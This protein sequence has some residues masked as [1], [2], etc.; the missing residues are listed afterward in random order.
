MVAPP[1]FIGTGGVGSTSE[2]I[3]ETAESIIRRCVVLELEKQNAKL[4]MDQ[5]K[6]KINS[7]KVKSS[8][9]RQS[10]FANR[11]SRENGKKRKKLMRDNFGEDEKE[12]LK[13]DDQK[14]KKEMPDYLDEEKKEY[15][16]KRI[17]KEKNIT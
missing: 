14:R 2:L 15:S 13:K 12:Q 8:V 17:T 7:I 16:K 1:K 11:T 3:S 10:N 6:E 4:A 9:K 5:Q